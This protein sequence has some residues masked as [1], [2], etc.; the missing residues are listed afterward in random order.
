MDMSFANQS[1]GIEYLIQNYKKLEKKVYPIPKQ[2]DEKIAKIKLETMGISID[3]LT[4]EQEE[5][6]NA[7]EMGT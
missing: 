4:K 7:W 2:I 5:Y 3:T 6:L 1:F